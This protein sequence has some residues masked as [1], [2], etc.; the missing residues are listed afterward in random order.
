MTHDADISA[1]LLSVCISEY[2]VSKVQVQQEGLD[3]NSK[4]KFLAHANGAKFWGKSMTVMKQ[5]REILLDE[6][7]WKPL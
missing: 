2:K 4:W 1:P 7:V 5:K 3:L 6:L